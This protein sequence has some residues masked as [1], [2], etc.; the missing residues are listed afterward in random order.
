MNIAIVGLGLI[1]G[2]IGL[3]ARGRG[4]QVVAFDNDPA[5][6]ARGSS[7]VL[8]LRPWPARWSEAVSGAE[9]TFVCGPV[10]ELPG[11]V[12]RCLSTCRPGR[13]HRR[14]LD[15]GPADGSRGRRTATSWADIPVCGSEARGVTNAR[16]ELFDGATWFLTP[17]A[18]TDPISLRTVHGYVSSLGARPVAID[19]DAHDRLVALTSHLPHALANLLANQAGAGRIDGH[20]PLP[21]WA[22]RFAT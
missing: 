4:D 18:A 10:A 13:R 15:Q 14:G 2:S 8:R 6:G 16:A 9:L 12:A 17:G 11:L 1:G 19:A 3:A 21:R 22:A 5:A 7:R 20:D